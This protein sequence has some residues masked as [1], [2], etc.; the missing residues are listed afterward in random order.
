MEILLIIIIIILG[1]VN[2][3]FCYLVNKAYDERLVREFIIE[4][5]VLM[6]DKNK[7]NLSDTMRDG[8]TKSK[9]HIKAKIE[10]IR[11]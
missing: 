5:L 8:V 7:I 6:I 1:A 11:E 10:K 9:F 2:L 3:W 4:K